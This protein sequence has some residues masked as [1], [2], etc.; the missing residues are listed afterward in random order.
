MTLQLI[1]LHSCV[2][3]SFR[4]LGTVQKYTSVAGKKK[5]QQ[6]GCEDMKVQPKIVFRLQQQTTEAVF[7]YASFLNQYVQSIEKRP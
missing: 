4:A 1:T 3:T 2:T 7:I 5:L 6:N